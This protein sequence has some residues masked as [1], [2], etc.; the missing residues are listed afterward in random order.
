MERGHTPYT[1]FGGGRED[2]I[3]LRN[4]PA[5]VNIPGRALRNST[6]LVDSCLAALTR[7]NTESYEGGGSADT[8][9]RR[10]HAAE[11]V[12]HRCEV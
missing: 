5:P 12:K 2:S 11:V 6:L 7:L 4:K 3:Y 9:T 8:E 10:K 1:A